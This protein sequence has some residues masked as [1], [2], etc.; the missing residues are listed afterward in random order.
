MSFA[1]MIEPVIDHSL[2]IALRRA[3]V[4][5]VACAILAALKR[6]RSA[7]E[8]VGGYST[9]T[10]VDGA[11]R[12]RL[13]IRKLRNARVGEQDKPARLPVAGPSG[14]RA[15][16]I[17]VAGAET[18]LIYGSESDD[19]TGLLH[20]SFVLLDR[21]IEALNGAPDCE[22]LL[23]RLQEDDERIA[24]AVGLEEPHAHASVH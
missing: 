2:T 14:N 12:D 11:I 5:D 17:M 13:L 8:E 19:L 21:L 20:T 23:T 15:E 3:P 10:M 4:P 7:I 18:C 6:V 16:T 24:I 1:E 9:V 22:E